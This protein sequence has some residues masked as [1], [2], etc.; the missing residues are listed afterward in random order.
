[1]TKE[2]HED[3]GSSTNCWLCDNAYADGDVKVRDK[4]QYHWEIRGSAHRDCKINIKLNQIKLNKIPTV[5]FN[6]KDYGSHFIIQELG[7]FQ[8]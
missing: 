1:M 6:L 7:N 4:L 2:V 3:F 8:K 5:F